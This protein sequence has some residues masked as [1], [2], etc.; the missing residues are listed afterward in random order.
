[1]KPGRGTGTPLLARRLSADPLVVIGPNYAHL[2]L[3]PASSLAPW[4]ADRAC[5]TL[6]VVHRTLEAEPGRRALVAAYRAHL[7]RYPRHR[8]LVLCNT[9]REHALLGG[10]GVP[11]VLCNHNI[12][13]DDHVYDV[14]RAQPKLFDALY[15]ARLQ[16]FKRHELCREVP[17]LALIYDEIER[18]DPTYVA[19]VQAAL[20]HATF[21]NA[22]VAGAG[23]ARPAHARA[24]E[25]INR[26]LAERG[27]ARLPPAAVAAYCN[28][29]RVGLCLS[30]EEG[31]MYAS[32]EYLLCGLPVV[33]TASRGGRDFF[34]DPAFTLTVPAV[35]GAVREAV[36]ALIARAIP[37]EAIRATTLARLTHERARLR[38]LLGAAFGEAGVEDELPAAWERL[39]AG[40]VWRWHTA[41]TLLGGR[42]TG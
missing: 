3:A 38:A 39:F 15:N 12:F 27:Y 24:G 2:P 37:P 32:M 10:A 5:T 9:E 13:V 4:L 21:V 14:D 1:M 22:L 18:S 30:A 20:P 29:A 41:D 34:F 36:A 28:R 31:A 26:V 6:V 42:D 19:A 40:P 16:P 23:P 11:A 8:V 25:L 17:R 33:T 35:P 7:S